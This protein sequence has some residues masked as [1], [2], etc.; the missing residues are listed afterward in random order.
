VIRPGRLLDKT[1]DLI[2]LETLTDIDPFLGGLCDRVTYYAGRHQGHHGMYIL[3]AVKLT[4][5][6]Q[7]FTSTHPDVLP[8][9]FHAIECVGRA[10]MA[11]TDS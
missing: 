10:E 7:L 2:V 3:S 4:S 8:T 1:V 5:H 6:E 11:D 9:T